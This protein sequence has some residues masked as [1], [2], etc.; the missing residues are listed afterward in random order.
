LKLR[1]EDPGINSLALYGCG[2][3]SRITTLK[4]DQ[5]QTWLRC[6]DRQHSLA[7]KRSVGNTRG[8]IS[9]AGAAMRC[10]VTLDLKS[11]KIDVAASPG[12]GPPM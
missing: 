1:E 11:S 6:I 5:L 10:E 2:A 12:D 9:A 8:V 3:Y 4:E 7:N